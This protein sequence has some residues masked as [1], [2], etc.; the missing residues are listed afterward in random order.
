MT[1][2][3]TVYFWQSDLNS[4]VLK[5]FACLYLDANSWAMTVLSAEAPVG[6][7]VEKPLVLKK[8]SPLSCHLDFCFLYQHVSFTYKT[9]QSVSWRGSAPGSM[10]ILNRKAVCRHRKTT[11]K[12]VLGRVWL[13][14]REK[15]GD[16]RRSTWAST[17]LVTL[18]FWSQLSLWFRS[19]ILILIC[20]L[21]HP[22]ERLDEVFYV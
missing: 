19:I 1:V 14:A 2:S 15:E 16:P 18:P 21:F 20:A 11:Y 6:E 10:L 13:T 12:P 4:Y 22:S 7:I 5:E 3:A 8:C 17:P 9:W